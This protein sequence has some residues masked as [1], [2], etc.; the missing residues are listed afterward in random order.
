M[1]FEVPPQ[2]FT[3]TSCTWSKT[4]PHP[5]G[6]CRIEG[7]DGFLRCPNCGGAIASRAATWFEIA[8]ARLGALRQP[9]W[10]RKG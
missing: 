9:G 5:V 10:G 7:L 3:C 4:T 6:D 1:A 8:V 2:T